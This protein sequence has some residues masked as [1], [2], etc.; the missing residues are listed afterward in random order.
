[1]ARALR[2]DKFTIA[3]LAATLDL[4]EDAGWAKSRLPVL[5]AL[6]TPPEELARRAAS[7]AD[8]LRRTTDLEVREVGTTSEVGGGAVPA[9]GLPTTAVA[10]RHEAHSAVEL[11]AEMRRLSVPVVGRIA[12]GEVLL[13]PRSLDPAE[14]AECA[15]VL[16]ERF[17]GGRG[18]G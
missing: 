7:L 1:M 2:V 5:R 15:R 14:D 16:A 4:L 9:E 10:L 8:E 13:D 11:A 6:E 17:R 12:E 18:G 3:A